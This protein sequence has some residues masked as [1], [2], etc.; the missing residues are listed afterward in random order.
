[1]WVVMTVRHTDACPSLPNTIGIWYF[2]DETQI[3]E[4]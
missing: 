3:M 4:G 2:A 1:M